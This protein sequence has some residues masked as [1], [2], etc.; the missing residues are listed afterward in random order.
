[1]THHGADTIF[2]IILHV[3]CGTWIPWEGIRYHFNGFLSIRRYEYFHYRRETFGKVKF[4][5]SYNICGC[6]RNMMPTIEQ[7]SCYLTFDHYL[8]KKYLKKKCIVLIYKQENKSRRIFQWHASNSGA[9]AY[10]YLYLKNNLIILK[11]FFLLF[12]FLP[13]QYSKSFRLNLR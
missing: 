13:L 3:R 8:M 10:L 4:V 2:Q 7:K 1:M 6:W 11:C 9:V 12:F 5:L